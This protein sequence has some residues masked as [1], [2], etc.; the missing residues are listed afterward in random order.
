VGLS[1]L[2]RRR[3][4]AHRDWKPAAKSLMKRLDHSMI[5]VLIA[6]TYTPFALLLL[7]GTASTVILTIAWAGALAGIT[8]RMLW[9]TAPRWAV[10]GPYLLVGW[11]ALFVLP[12]FLHAGGVAVFVLIA[13]GGLIYTLG[14]VVYATKW[15][16]PWPKTFG[17][18]EVFHLM[19]ILAGVAMY[20]AVSITVYR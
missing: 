14:A 15:P 9:I 7:H 16:N 4:R 10:I 18:H 8:M 2:L 20:V 5:L 11:V 17:F 3:D 13:S 12:D 19:T 1:D 6:G